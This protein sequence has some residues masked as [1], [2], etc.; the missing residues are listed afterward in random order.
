MLD[1]DREPTGDEMR[2][3]QNLFAAYGPLVSNHTHTQIRL[4]GDTN[5][6]DPEALLPAGRY[7]TWG[8]LALFP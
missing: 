6:T 8:C 5:F 2:I 7:N 3:A 1:L 4:A